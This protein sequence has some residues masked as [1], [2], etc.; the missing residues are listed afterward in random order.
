MRTEEQMKKE[1]RK[2][3]WIGVAKALL[4]LI[5]GGIIGFV[6][7]KIVILANLI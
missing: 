4:P 3:M 6:V 5:A 1:M 2:H 7:G